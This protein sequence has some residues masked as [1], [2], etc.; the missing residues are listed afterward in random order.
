MTD[1]QQ[2]AAVMGVLTGAVVSLRYLWKLI[3]RLLT[4]ITTNMF[5][6]GDLRT[7]IEALSEQVRFIVC[8][9]K[10]NGGASVRD[11]LNR[12]ELRQVLQEQRQWAILS[13]M[14]VGVF[15]TDAE[16]EFIY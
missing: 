10:P 8:E 2:I 4:K 14:S 12:I 1:W 6:I 15:E 3:P 9:L 13:D 11:S 5:G 16:G 7:D